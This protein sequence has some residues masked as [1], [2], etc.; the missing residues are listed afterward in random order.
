MTGEFIVTDGKIYAICNYCKSLIRLNKPIFGSLHACLP[1]EERAKL[2]LNLRRA[3]IEQARQAMAVQQQS[4][5]KVA[6]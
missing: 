4:I 2:D 3:E 6:K 1:P 5:A